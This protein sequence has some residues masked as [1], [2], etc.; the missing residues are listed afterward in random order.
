M[1]FPARLFL[2][3][4]I[5]IGLQPLVVRGQ[6]SDYGRNAISFNLTRL[7]VNE[8]NMSFEHWY[9]SRRS[10]EIS[11]GLVY[12]NS[13]FREQFSEWTN[14]QPFA[15][16]GFAARVHY[17]IFKRIEGASRWKDYIAPGIVYRYLY[18]DN[19][20]FESGS[21]LTLDRVSYAERVYQHRVRSK[22]GLEFLWGKVYEMNS[23][24]SFDFYYGAGVMFTS[25]RRFVIA[26]EPYNNDLGEKTSF[27][28][29]PSIQAGIK[30]RIRF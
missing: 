2:S 19:Q 18:Y 20:W 12:V 16:R 15:E 23:T 25:S 5:L 13:F 28:V 24:L 26:S 6:E 11:G 3:I 1:K 14:S 30:F 29:R 22:F 9:S 17:K 8:I 27:Y 7:A 4:A 10:L 21:F